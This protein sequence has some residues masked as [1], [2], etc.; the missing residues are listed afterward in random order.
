MKWIPGGTFH[1]GSEEGQPDEKPVHEVTV[2]G[3]S[4]TIAELFMS[5]EV[6]RTGPP[7]AERRNSSSRRNFIAGKQAGRPRGERRPAG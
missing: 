3:F 2:D 6:S 7:I 4:G 1:M 5:K